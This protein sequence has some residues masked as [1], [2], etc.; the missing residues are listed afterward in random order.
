MNGSDICAR[1]YIQII[2]KDRLPFI[3]IIFDYVSKNRNQTLYRRRHTFIYTYI[4]IVHSLQT[5][6]LNAKPILVD[7]NDVSE[8]KE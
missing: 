8:T 5:N 3:Y 6:S 7:F 1:D 4:N 2:F